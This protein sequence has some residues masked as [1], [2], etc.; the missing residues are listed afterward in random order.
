M[1]TRG[2]RG[3]QQIRPQPGL[4]DEIYVKPAMGDDGSALDAALRLASRSGGVKDA[5]MPIPFLGPEH[6]QA[7]ID[8]VLTE[9]D[10]P[11]T[12]LHDHD[13]RRSS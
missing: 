7:E 4:F 3:H 12:S 1:R 9:P 5:G 6:R 10:G 11:R 2:D 13:R 8:K